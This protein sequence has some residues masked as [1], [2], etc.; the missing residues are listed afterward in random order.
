MGTWNGDQG[1][2]GCI[3]VKKMESINEL[4]VVYPNME[5]KELLQRD[6]W[7]QLMFQDIPSVYEDG[8]LQFTHVLRQLGIL[9]KLQDVWENIKERRSILESDPESVQSFMQQV[10]RKLSFHAILGFE[11]MGIKNSMT[12]RQKI[13]NMVWDIGRVTTNSWITD[14]LRSKRRWMRVHWYRERKELSL[15]ILNISDIDYVTFGWG[16]SRYI[17]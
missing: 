3:L 14:T 6:P 5:E 17:T 10:L 12:D 4:D 13:W 16:A 2:C 9:W 11:Q 7:F 1:I 15:T 8:K